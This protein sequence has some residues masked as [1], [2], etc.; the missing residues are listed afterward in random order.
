MKLVAISHSHSP[1]DHHTQNSALPNHIINI[2]IDH[3]TNITKAKFK[4]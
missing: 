1:S 4:K 3:Y 2:K